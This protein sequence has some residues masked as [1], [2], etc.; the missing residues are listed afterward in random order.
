MKQ[1]SELFDGFFSEISASLIGKSGEEALRRI[2]TE[3]RISG[4]LES[5]VENHTD[6]QI[7]IMNDARIAGE[8][9]ADFLIQIDDYDIRLDILDTLDQQCH[10]QFEKLFFYR[11]IFEK[12]PSTEV[13]FITWTTIDLLTLQLTLIDI[14]T[15]LKKVIHDASKNGDSN[16][17]ENGIIDLSEQV[18]PINEVFEEFFINKIRVW[19]K[20]VTLRPDHKNT[21][22]SL[23][24]VFINHFKKCLDVERNRPY[25]VDEKRIA[26]NKLSENMNT[27]LFKDVLE[28]ALNGEPINELVESLIKLPK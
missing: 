7:R 12:N 13:L 14:D 25:K 28:K 20:I 23:Q 26:A 18:N 3:R 9:G 1:N 15:L 16:K 21:E 17:H 6:I 5:V 22:S 4:F 24:Q 8:T 11:R 2:N 19:E 10:L 27:K